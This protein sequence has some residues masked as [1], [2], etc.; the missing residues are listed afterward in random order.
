MRGVARC[1]PAGGTASV[2]YVNRAVCAYANA[3]INGSI[4]RANKRPY[5]MSAGI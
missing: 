2:T 5:S 3:R 1:I 4:R